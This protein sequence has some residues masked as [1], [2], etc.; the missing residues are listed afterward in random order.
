MQVNNSFKITV[1]KIKRYKAFYFLFNWKLKLL[2]FKIGGE[3]R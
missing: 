3:G 2:S 1:I